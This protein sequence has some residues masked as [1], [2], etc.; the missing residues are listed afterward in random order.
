MEFHYQHALLPD[1]NKV[2][3]DINE[4]STRLLGK[5]SHIDINLPDVSDAGR[6]YFGDQVRNIRSTLRNFSYILS[7]SIA[8]SDVPY[9]EFVF[10][11]HGGGVGIL[12]LLAKELGLGTVIYNDLWAPYCKD[13]Q[14]IAEAVEADR[15]DHY[16]LGDM[17]ELV[18]FLKTN[19]ICCNALASYD[20]IEHIYDIETFLLKLSDLSAGPFNIVMASSANPFNPL[21]RRHH[22]EFQRKA[23]YGGREK[24]EGCREDYLTKAYITVRQEIISKHS[25]SLSDEDVQRLAKATR[26]LI[27]PDIKKVVDEYLKTG[28][29]RQ[30][31]NHPTNTVN[32]HTGNWAERLHNIEHLKKILLNEGF[33]VDILAGYY[34][35]SKSNHPLKRFMGIVLNPL[36]RILK[37]KGLFIAPFYTIYANKSGAS[38]KNI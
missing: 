27:E 16:V 18:E 20:V 9:D 14:I 23:E 11:D 10:I 25:A 38:E 19:S 21:I 1:D 5:L 31:P 35:N 36:I 33:K 28:E 15:A 3:R 24:E 34:A 30:E 37:S 26:G 29:I 22:I 2:L 13:A 6:K 12:S 4:A 32:P 8:Y 17:D 7:W